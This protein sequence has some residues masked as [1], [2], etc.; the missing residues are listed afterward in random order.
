MTTSALMRATGG[1]LIW[2]RHKNSPS[3]PMG[4]VTKYTALFYESIVSVYIG[5][6]APFPRPAIDLGPPYLGEGGAST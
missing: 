6:F 3:S 4:K 1:T 5:G 2:G